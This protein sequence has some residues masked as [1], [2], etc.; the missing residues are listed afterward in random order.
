MTATQYLA[1][2]PAMPAGERIAY[3]HTP[4]N[5]PA[6]VFLPGYMSD[7]TGSKAGAVFDAGRAAGREALLFDYSGCGASDGMFAQ[8]TLTRWR[9]EAL[10]LI[11]AKI[12]SERIILVGSSMGAW[13]MVPLGLALGRNHDQDRARLAGMVGIAAAPDFTDW[14]FDADLKARLAAGETVFQPNP[15]G[16]EPTPTHAAFWRDG[17]AQRVL[18]GAPVAITAPVRLIHGLDD[19]DVPWRVSLDL[20]HA[21]ASEDVTVTL[22][23]RGDHRLSRP[24]DIALL[25]RTIAA[26]V[27]TPGS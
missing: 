18:G 3:R 7:M 12:A 21:L 13:L 15:Y 27:E 16:P 17:Q 11:E 4:G 25:L 10:A 8:G 5:G 1:Q 20:A 9:G 22:I 26:L 24:E 23:K 19:Q 6:I 2:D 14:G